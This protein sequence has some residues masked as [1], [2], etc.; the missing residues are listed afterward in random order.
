MMGILCRCW[1][2]LRRLWVRSW[3]LRC[4]RKRWLRANFADVIVE[5]R[6]YIHERSG[7]E[8]QATLK[9]NLSR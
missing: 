4:C 7:A 8:F 3:R 1:R 6:R 2:G 9:Q 5:V